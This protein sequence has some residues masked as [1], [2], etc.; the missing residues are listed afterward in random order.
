VSQASTQSLQ[1]HIDITTFVWRKGDTYS[2]FISL[3]NVYEIKTSLH[4]INFRFSMLGNFVRFQV[5]FRLLCHPL[6]YQEEMLKRN[7][8]KSVWNAEKK[9]GFILSYMTQII[10]YLLL[11]LHTCELSTFV[12]SS[13][14][15]GL[16]SSRVRAVSHI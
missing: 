15:L 7:L 8:Q 16:R 1:W 2:Y 4:Q 10:A 14:M 13:R 6:S 11:E 12:C 3:Q 9:K 5:S